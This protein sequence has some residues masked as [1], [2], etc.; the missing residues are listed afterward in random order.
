MGLSLPALQLR[1]VRED[2]NAATAS[3]PRID[4]KIAAIHHDIRIMGLPDNGRLILA[5]IDLRAHPVLLLIVLNYPLLGR[6]GIH[7]IGRRLVHTDALPTLIAAK[8]LIQFHRTDNFLQFGVIVLVLLRFAAALCV[9]V[10]HLQPPRRRDHDVLQVRLVRVVRAE[11]ADQALAGLVVVA[12][13][14][15]AATVFAA[16]AA[17]FAALEE[18]TEL[19]LLVFV[20]G[21]AGALGEDLVFDR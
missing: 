20:H 17:V 10:L 13:Y 12:G 3:S 21:G 2:Q 18:V 19:V 7:D 5:P 4:A 16:V 15:E 8:R 14:A 11:V 6:P 9:L 1:V